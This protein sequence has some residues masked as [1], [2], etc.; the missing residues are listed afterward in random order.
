MILSDNR[1][2]SYTTPPV[3]PSFAEGECANADKKDRERF[4]ILNQLNNNEEPEKVAENRDYLWAKFCSKCPIQKPCFEWGMA[5]E[6]WGVWA[7]TTEFDRQKAR[8]DSA[9]LEYGRNRLGAG[10][11]PYRRRKA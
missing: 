2:A 5:Y 4:F 11:Q 1:K 6:D 10:Y 7:G 3:P 9:L 8:K